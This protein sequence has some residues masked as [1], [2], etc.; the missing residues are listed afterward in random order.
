MLLPD[1][2][3]YRY[4][5]PDGSV[6]GFG[7][8]AVAEL[9]LESEVRGDGDV[10]SWLSTPLR[11]ASRVGIDRNPIDADNV[12]QTDWLRACIWPE[13]LDR[14][15]RLE[16]ALAQAREARL[17]LRR[18]D[19]FD[20][21][22]AA[23]AEAPQDAVVVVLSSHVLPYLTEDDRQRFADLVVDLSRTR[24]LMLVLNEDHRLSRPFGVRA[25]GEDGYVASSFVDY[26]N[27]EGP[28]ATALA[29]VDAHGI[30]LEWL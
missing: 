2:Y 7:D 20:L 12:D 3:G 29:K 21:L 28:T 18:G 24:D 8:A 11:I 19:L 25:P 13:H 5:Q 27:T 10:P 30:W 14:L 9:V 15:A 4:V 23:V 17:D 26:T 1:R 16:A 6:F 22:P